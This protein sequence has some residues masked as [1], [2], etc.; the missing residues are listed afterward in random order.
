MKK[1]I[2]LSV[3]LAIIIITTFHFSIK[4]WDVTCK[5]YIIEHS[6]EIEYLE[7]PM[8]E[9]GIYTIDSCDMYY[10]TEVTI[11]SLDDSSYFIIFWGDRDSWLWK[12][13]LDKSFEVSIP[14][15]RSKGENVDKDLKI[16]QA[17]KDC[18]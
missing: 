3:T 16:L 18:N 2:L 4:T 1:T 6:D 12:Y 15:D 5:D 17:L 13:K 7:V 11:K 8:F 9:D 10:F 14:Y